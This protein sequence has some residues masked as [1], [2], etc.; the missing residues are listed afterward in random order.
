MWMGVLFD[1]E[2]G[3]RA[4]RVEAISQD[5]FFGWL[6]RKGWCVLVVYLEV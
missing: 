2:A 1:G 4:G 3:I 5:E 6:E